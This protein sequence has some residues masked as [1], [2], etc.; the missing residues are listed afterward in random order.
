MLLWWLDNTNEGHPVRGGEQKARMND[1][2]EALLWIGGL[3]IVSGVAVSAVAFLLPIIGKW[4]LPGDVVIQT[5]N[6]TC[7]FPL[8]SM[9]LLSI[10][11]TIVLNV[12]IRLIKK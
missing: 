5:K 6:V 4:R 1:V 3:L 10:V 2:R 9:L 8:A 12:V 7:F 11:L